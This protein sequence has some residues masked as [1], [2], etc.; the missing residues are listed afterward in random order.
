MTAKTMN[1]S[2]PETYAHDAPPKSGRD[3]M[4]QVF[5]AVIEDS[6]LLGRFVEQLRR[7]RFTQ[8][9]LQWLCPRV[10]DHYQRTAQAPGVMRLRGWLDADRLD[11]DKRAL[12]DDFVTSI[13]QQAQS[14]DRH[15]YYAEMLASLIRQARV[16]VAQRHLESG[17]IEKA[18]QELNKW[19]ELESV[20]EVK[21][22]MSY[23]DIA[24]TPVETEPWLVEGLV[25]RKGINLVYGTPEAGKT[26]LLLD[27]NAAVASGQDLLG[28]KTKQCN[29]LY[30]DEDVGVE[31]VR[32]RAP[33]LALGRHLDWQ[34]LPVRCRFN[35]GVR[36]DD[37]GDWARRLISDITEHDI[38]LL[39][40]E[41][42]RSV[43]DGDENSSKDVS[44]LFRSLKLI[45][46]RTGV[47]IVLSHHTP[48]DGNGYRGSGVFGAD[49]DM[50]LSVDGDDGEFTV[51]VKKSRWGKKTFQPT[52]VRLKDGE[53]GSV[54]LAIVSR[55][56]SKETR[57]TKAELAESDIILILRNAPEPMTYKELLEAMKQAGDKE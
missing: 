38:G 21:P 28:L 30:I 53:D 19:Q 16:S 56:D 33:K 52:R 32:L 11:D 8:P 29:V 49:I 50:S 43:F 13:E 57:Q 12:V 9:P 40:I 17:R 22:L 18:L 20:G 7:T 46:E 14:E 41:T 42:A 24:A 55:R 15:G 10:C 47:T 23:A 36:L 2:Q 26:W 39:V 34:S 27:L 54:A 45:R 25:K 44:K 4:A 51:T 31:Q 5:R 37:D 48:K 1:R 35:N 6:T 3:A